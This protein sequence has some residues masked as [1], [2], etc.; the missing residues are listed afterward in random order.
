MIIEIGHSKIISEPKIG[1]II[2]MEPPAKFDYHNVMFWE[3]ESRRLM[4]IT[5]TGRLVSAT[6]LTKAKEFLMNDCISLVER[7]KWVCKPIKGY[8]K[9]SYHIT[10]RDN[11]TCD[12]QGFKA[13]QNC[14]HIIAVK[15]FEFINNHNVKGG[16]K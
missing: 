16:A 14:S 13:N 7:N 4:R 9:H 12:C 8:N 6:L 5:K 2:T 10:F 11:W 1:D 15:Q 3:P